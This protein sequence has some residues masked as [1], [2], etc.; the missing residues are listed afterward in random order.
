MTRTTTL[1]S[2]LHLIQHLPF[3]SSPGSIL[4][5]KSPVI[6][7][8]EHEIYSSTSAWGAKTDWS[9]YRPDLIQRKR[10]VHHPG[11]VSVTNVSNGD[12]CKA[13]IISLKRILICRAPALFVAAVIQKR[14]A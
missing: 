12:A 14:N 7:K 8:V 5:A 11:Q 10:A 1:I 4:K 6:N 13:R 3:A 2:E 9:Y